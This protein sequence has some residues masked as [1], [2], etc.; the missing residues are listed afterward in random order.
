MSRINRAAGASGAQGQRD[1]E[2]GTEEAPNVWLGQL[3][4]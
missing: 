3:H 4:T 2:R 1:R